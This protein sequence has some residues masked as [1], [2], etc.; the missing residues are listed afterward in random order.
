MYIPPFPPFL[1]SFP[2]QL[3]PLFLYQPI[4]I[5]KVLKEC[6]DEDTINVFITHTTWCDSDRLSLFAQVIRDG[7][8]SA[9][10]VGQAK[11]L[12][13][14]L[15]YL[16]DVE[17]SIA[18]QRMNLTNTMLLNLISDNLQ[19]KELARL[20]ANWVTSRQKSNNKFKQWVSNN[21]SDVTG[22]LSQVPPATPVNTS[23]R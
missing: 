22:V 5:E 21:H 17:D 18:Q 19:N 7:L 23:T 15:A 2:P 3:I 12:L 14:S 20:M 9:M 16:Q 8:A 1:P 4:F 10:N 11:V 6:S 13:Q